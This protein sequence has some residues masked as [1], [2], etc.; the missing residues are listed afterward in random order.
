MCNDY[1]VAFHNDKTCFVSNC[2]V[3]IILPGNVE[4]LIKKFD[5]F[6][7]TY[8]HLDC[9][10]TLLKFRFNGKILVKS[11]QVFDNV[12]RAVGLITETKEW[13]ECRALQERGSCGKKFKKHF[14]SSFQKTKTTQTSRSVLAERIDKLKK[15][16]IELE[17]IKNSFLDGHSNYD[18]ILI[19]FR[20]KSL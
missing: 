15:T 1:C 19:S 12:Q 10:Y 20:I 11:R 3:H 6:C 8:Q 13:T 16:K 5:T 4:E 18:C 17:R 2:K 7:F 14:F 9:L